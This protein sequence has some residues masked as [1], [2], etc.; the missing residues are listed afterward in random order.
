MLSLLLQNHLG[1]R[2]GTRRTWIRRIKFCILK[3]SKILRHGTY[4]LQS[5]HR[6][7]AQD[8]KIIKARVWTHVPWVSRRACYPEANR[9]QGFKTNSLNMNKLFGESIHWIQRTSRYIVTQ[10]CFTHWCV[11]GKS[12]Q[13]CGIKKSSFCN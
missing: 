13:L 11:H 12:W 1:R 4:S 10:I 6:I 7:C 9:K 8:F 5:L 3:A 2:R